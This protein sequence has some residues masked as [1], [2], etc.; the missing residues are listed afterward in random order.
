MIVMIVAGFGFRGAATAAS[1]R[2]ALSRTG[3]EAHVSALATADD[4]ARAPGM[5]ALAHGLGLP[6]H[7][8][9]PQDL[10]Q[11][12]TSTNSPV[13]QQ[14]RNTGSVAEA[15]ALTAAGPGARLLSTRVISGDRLATCAIACAP[16]TP[17]QGEPQ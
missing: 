11:A 16:S 17:I 2:D 5:A 10:A 8:V 12:E 4:K 9:P 7:P 13:A 6:V 1:L 15:T 3:Y 14:H